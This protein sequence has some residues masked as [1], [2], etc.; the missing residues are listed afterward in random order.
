MALR[1]YD[2]H[3]RIE[4]VTSTA[5]AEHGGDP[6]ESLIAYVESNRHS[7]AD[8]SLAIWKLGRLGDARALPL[9]ERLRTG[10]PCD[11]ARF[12]CQREIDKAL[13]RLASREPRGR[14]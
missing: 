1:A 6:V 10:Q 5:R 3:L 4:R 11:H 8:K 12:V 14:Y 13:A 9:L 2:A 7:P